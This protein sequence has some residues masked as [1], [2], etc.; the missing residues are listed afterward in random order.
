MP[1]IPPLL[2]YSGPSQ[3]GLRAMMQR[4][5]RMRRWRALAIRSLRRICGGQVDVAHA[6]RAQQWSAA[7]ELSMRGR[8]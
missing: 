6:A 8:A 5:G 2:R 1:P 3:P 4:H 7:A